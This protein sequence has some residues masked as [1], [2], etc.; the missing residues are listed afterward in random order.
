MQIPKIIF[1]TSRTRPPSYLV[2][3]IKQKCPGWT[4]IHFTDE[5]II[6]FFL[7]NP[8]EEFSNIINIFQSLKVG[9]HKSDLF[10][11]YFLY[12]KGGVHLDSDAMFQL[13]VENICLDYDFFSVNSSY[14]PGCIFQGLIGAVPNNEI[15]YAALKDAYIVNI[16]QLNSDYLL[17]CRNLY[18]IIYDKDT[19]WSCKLK[20]YSET[21]CSDEIALVVDNERNNILILA[22]YFGLKIVPNK[23]FNKSQILQHKVLVKFR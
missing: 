14:C 3:M 10:R 1:Q 18:N 17:L 2:N 4:Y 23:Y 7:K 15:V 16:N 13:N 6:N 11:Y 9:A 19:I 5:D 8:I 20:I 12:I 21:Y 22:H